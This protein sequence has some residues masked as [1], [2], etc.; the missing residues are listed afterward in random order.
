VKP[1]L[2]TL[3]PEIGRQ[4]SRYTAQEVTSGQSGATVLRLGSP[5][6]PTLYLKWASGAEA[7]EVE[8]ESG[9]LRWLGSNGTPCARVLWAVRTSDAFWLLSTAVPGRSLDE[10]REAGADVLVPLAAEALRTLHSLP[11]DDCPLDCRFEKL[12]RHA[13]DRVEAGLV[14]EDDFD[15][16]RAGRSASDILSELASLE[17][18]PEDLVVTHGD[19]TFENLMEQDGRFS[20]FVDCGR[21]GVADRHRDLALIA[22]SIDEAFGPHWT[23]RFFEIYGATIDP[24]KIEAYRIMDEFF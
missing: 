8:R 16:E 14:N 4:L 10:A 5:S 21:L 22:R 20:G 17:H 23:A 7:D 13:T 11:V 12:L 2:P 15:E 24:R 1:A 18:G 19:A 3:P 6:G 9:A